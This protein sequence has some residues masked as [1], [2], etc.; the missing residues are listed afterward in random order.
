MTF[1][2]DDTVTL[3]D[4]GATWMTARQ[5]RRLVLPL[6]LKGM[7]ERNL[8]EAD[9]MQICDCGKSGSFDPRHI[10]CC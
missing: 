2:E 5:I 3:P 6:R 7:K 1:S 4:A 10:L 8:Y 9:A